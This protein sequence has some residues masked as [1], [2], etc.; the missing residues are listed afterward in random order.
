MPK[1]YQKELLTPEQIYFFD[2]AKKIYEEVIEYNSL[3]L[4][5]SLSDI[6]K[7]YYKSEYNITN[8]SDI[9]NKIKDFNYLMGN[10]PGDVKSAL[11]FRILNKLPIYI[12]RPPLLFS[13]PCYDFLDKDFS[14]QL[15]F[16][17]ENSS[18]DFRKDDTDSKI[19]ISQ[20]YWQLIEIKSDNELLVSFEKWLDLGFVWSLKKELLPLDKT[21]MKIVNYHNPGVPILTLTQL[22]EE[23]KF[24]V[25][26]KY[27]EFKKI[28]SSYKQED[29][30]TELNSFNS[31]INNNLYHTAK[32]YFKKRK[33]QNLPDYP[34]EEELNLEISYNL[35]QQLT[36]LIVIKDILYKNI[37]TLSLLKGKLENTH[38]LNIY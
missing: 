24:K 31:I 25:I 14:Y 21:T 15:P 7:E 10:S 4:F 38:I 33:E 20:S 35:T 13:Y 19:N 34:S 17:Q 2:T 27:E 5:K 36:D 3:E 1:F 18:I 28:I 32:Q 22:Q 16:S 30:N 8:D 29:Y 12:H 11:F 9:L 23:V 37:W 26:N 6:E